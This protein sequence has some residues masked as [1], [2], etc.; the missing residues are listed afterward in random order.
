MLKFISPFLLIAIGLIIYISFIVITSKESWRKV[1]AIIAIAI[2]ISLILID[3]ILRA[4]LSIKYIFIVELV[5]LLLFSF[6][7]LLKLRTLTFIVPN[8]FNN[9]YFSIVYGV[10]GEKELPFS[11]RLSLFATIKV[12]H[13]KVIFTS[14]TK[15]TH[16]PKVSIKLKNGTRLNRNKNERYG[17]LI[18]NSSFNCEGKTYRYRTWKVEKLIEGGFGISGNEVEEQKD[19]LKN[20]FVSIKGNCKQ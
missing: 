6:S 8:N 10:D 11:K 7:Y 5:A 3:A 15:N 12:P 9:D 17:Y 19:L 16:L 2:T 20:H 1:V 4:F 14:S 18:A 13:N